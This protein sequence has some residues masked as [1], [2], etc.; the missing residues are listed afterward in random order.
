MGL[1][2]KLINTIRKIAALSKEEKIIPVLTLVKEEMLFSSKIAL[3][4]GGSSGIGLS[5]AENLISKG[6][7]VIIAGTNESKLEKAAQKLGGGWNHK[8]YC[9]QCN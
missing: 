7:K 1:K 5:I 8:D 4:T 6:C 9:Y 3:I 2:K